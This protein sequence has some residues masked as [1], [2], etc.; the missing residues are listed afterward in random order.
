MF[1]IFSC[2]LFDIK[3]FLEKIF[4]GKKLKSDIFD[5][6]GVENEIRCYLLK[7]G[8]AA[9]VPEDPKAFL[10]LEEVRRIILEADVIPTYRF[11]GEDSNVGFTEFV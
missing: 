5:Y 10:Q 6:A 8:G 3:K 2:E 4:D 1:T 11:L 7:A 9:F